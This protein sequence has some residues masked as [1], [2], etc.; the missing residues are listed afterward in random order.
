MSA[1]A[2]AGIFVILL[3]ICFISILC[4]LMAFLYKCFQTKKD[5]KIENG[6][7]QDCLTPSVAKNNSRDPKLILRRPSILVKKRSEEIVTTEFKKKEDTEGKIQKEQNPEEDKENR[8]ED[9]DLQKAAITVN[10]TTSVTDSKRPLKGVTFSREV[11]I[12]DLG[13]KYPTP[14]SYIQEHKE[15]K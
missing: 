15:R 1:D 5:G 6:S 7:C 11:I 9:D 3:L 4:L 14:Q 8:K 2:T 12:V 10:A 13:K